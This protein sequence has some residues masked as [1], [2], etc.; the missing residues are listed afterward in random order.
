LAR[1]IFKAAEVKELKSKVLITPPQIKRPYEEIEEPVEELEEL[2][3]MQALEE[4]EMEAPVSLEE[5]KD[6]ILQETEDIKQKAEIEAKRMRDEAE[7]AAFKI[8]QKNSI[9]ARKLKEEAEGEAKSI[10]ENAQ[11]QAEELLKGARVKAVS[12][13]QE[14]RSKAQ[15]EGKEEGYNTGKEEVERLIERLHIILNAAIDKRK[16]IIEN[17]ERQLLD[18]VLLITRKV[19]KVISESEKEVVIENIRE[20]L[21][22]VRG[23]TE[24]TIRVNLKDLNLSTK[25][26]KRFIS[27]VEGLQKITLEEDSRVDP[28]GCIVETSFGDIDARIAT[29]LSVIEEK[30]RELMPVKG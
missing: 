7:E 17:T 6:K 29:Q 11:R 24:I 12:M 3:E 9:D 16:V 10:H 20:A 30:I 21:K 18:L 4:A 2:T 15:E 5:E 23:E 8:M 28:G 14:A 26:K 13:L 19:V 25:N 1:K 22:K 27:L